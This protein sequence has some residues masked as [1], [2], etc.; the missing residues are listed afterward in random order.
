MNE[1]LQFLSE[2]PTFYLATVEGNIPKV[3]PF[4]F[5]M[6]Y[7]NKLYFCTSNQKDVYKQLKAN[8]HFEISTVS[9]TNEWL[10]LSGKAVFD[11]NQATQQA[12]LDAAPFLSRMYQVN[13]SKFELFYI[14]DATAI[15]RDMKGESRTIK[16]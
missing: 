4:G 16:F 13:D 15:I 10:R 14:E 7:Q 3:R 11:T 2:N 9:K 1:V 5:V 8:P 12:A 6:N